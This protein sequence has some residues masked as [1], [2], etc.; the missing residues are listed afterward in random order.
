MLGWR[1]LH[2]ITR[3]LNRLSKKGIEYV[4]TEVS[5]IDLTNRIIKTSTEDF[6][7]DYLVIALGADLAPDAVPGFQKSAHHI[8]DLEN[9]MKFRDAI[10][11]FSEGTVVMGI[12]SLPFKCPAA[13][14]EAA[15]LLDYHGR[16]IG[17]RDKV[18]IKFF[19]PEPLPMPVAGPV[20]G[21]MVKQ[22]EGRDISFSP[23]IKLASADEKKKEIVFENGEKMSF[24][25]LFAVPPHRSPKVVKDTDLVNE[26]GWIPVDK[27]A[28]KTKYDDVYA[29]G[30]ITAIKLPNGMM[31]PKAGVC[32]QRSKYSG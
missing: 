7:Y 18:D 12:S 22:L 13:P 32:P 30:D 27:K 5:K 11:Q 6:A 17:I 23:N 9:A 16:K 2:Q 20:I 28:L 24:N 3:D 29:L 26:A 25:L 19:T 10:N 1:E 15:L 21:N 14:Y 31:L 8:Y 4:N